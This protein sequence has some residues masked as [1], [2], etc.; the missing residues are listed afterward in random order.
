MF[1]LTCFIP[2]WVFAVLGVQLRFGGR[3]ALRGERQI[4]E[5]FWTLV[6]SLMVLM[7]AYVNIQYLIP[8]R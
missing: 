7:L 2:S 8:I 6:P 1:L 5:F 4:L 3:V